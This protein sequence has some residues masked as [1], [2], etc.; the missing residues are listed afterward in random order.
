[1]S[2]R[3]VLFW[4]HLAAGTVAGAVV[5]VMSVTGVLLTYEKQ[6]VAWAD[7]APRS[8]P[9]AG[10]TRLPLETLLAAVRA[11]RPGS[12]PTAVT[13]SSEPAAP[14]TVA[15]GR[16]GTVFVDAYDGRILGEGSSGPAPSSRR[17]SPGTAGS[18][19][20][21]RAGRWG[22]RSPAPPTWPSCSW[23]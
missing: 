13:V 2:L 9:A 16:A 7:G 10:A 11:A 6:M 1:M 21:A 5:L 19:P 18:A 17:S 3:R 22:R 8:T 12:T 15:L 20:T 14:V 23:S 4:L